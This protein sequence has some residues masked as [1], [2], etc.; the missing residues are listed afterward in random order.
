M[1]EEDKMPDV[2]AYKLKKAK[3]MI[4]AAGFRVEVEETKPLKLSKELVWH[5]EN[6][7]VIKQTLLPGNIIKIVVGCKMRREVY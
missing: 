3:A 6:A 7:Y 1:V 5:D 2:L 4:R